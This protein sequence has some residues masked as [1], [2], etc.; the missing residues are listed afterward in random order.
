V[1]ESLES[2]LREALRATVTARD[3]VPQA[4]ELAVREV[5]QREVVA[6]ELSI[7]R[8]LQLIGAGP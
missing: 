1:A 7:A 5:V 4:S 6:A 8:A 3:L 2:V